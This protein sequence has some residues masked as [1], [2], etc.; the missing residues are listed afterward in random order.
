MAKF[1]ALSFE[2]KKK[3]VAE[4]YGSQISLL[5]LGLINSPNIRRK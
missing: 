2:R 4:K 1:S 3:L 5:L